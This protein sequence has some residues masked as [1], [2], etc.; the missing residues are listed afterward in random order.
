[1][2]KETMVAKER[3]KARAKRNTAASDVAWPFAPPCSRPLAEHPFLVVC[4]SFGVGVG[5]ADA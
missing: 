1:M 2:Q 3:R 4:M 5:A